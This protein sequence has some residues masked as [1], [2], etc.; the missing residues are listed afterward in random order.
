M[1]K[2]LLLTHLGRSKQFIN[3]TTSLSQKLIPSCSLTASIDLIIKINSFI[4]VYVRIFR[5]QKLPSASRVHQ[6]SFATRNVD[7]R[8]ASS[9]LSN[10]SSGRIVKTVDRRTDLKNRPPAFPRGKDG[11]SEGPFRL[12][13]DSG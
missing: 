5:I 11:G 7:A 9:Q 2:N 12:S 6:L 1:L 3:S 13:L 8:F 10:Q 4:L